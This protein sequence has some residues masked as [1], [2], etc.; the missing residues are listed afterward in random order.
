MTDAVRFAGFAVAAA[1]T[2]GL[3]RIL[4]REMGAAAALAAG[5]ML[6]AAALSYIA[7]AAE[8]M[9]SLSRR[10]GMQD[11]TAVM[12]LKM[13]GIAYLTEFT[14]ELCRDAGE[15]G[16]GAKAAFC[17]KMLLLSQTVPLILEIGEMTLDM[18]G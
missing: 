11:E 7:P 14:A 4:R 1:L 16:L 13:I 12:L 2:A 18:I 5:L 17:G 15:A 8:E 6:F 10:A 3:L 9:I